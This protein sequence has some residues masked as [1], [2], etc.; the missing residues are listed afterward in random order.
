V[1]AAATRDDAG[2]ALAAALGGVVEKKLRLILEE[3]EEAAAAALAAGID[4]AA[5]AGAA[6]CPIV[7]IVMA[8]FAAE[9]EESNAEAEEGD[10]VN[11]VLV[12]PVGADEGTPVPLLARAVELE[13]PEK[14]EGVGVAPDRLDAEVGGREKPDAK[15]ALRDGAG[16]KVVELKV[17]LKVELTGD[18]VTVT[19][20]V[21]AEPQ[22]AGAV[23]EA[24][25][26]LEELA[27]EPTL[28]LG[29]PVPVPV[30]FTAEFALFEIPEGEVE[31]EPVSVQLLPDVE[32]VE[33]TDPDPE[34]PPEAP[35]WS[36][37]ATASACVSQVIDCYRKTAIR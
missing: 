6:D 36:I 22:P 19:V 24:T 18:A 1:L 9:R 11:V 17:E 13:T 28:E 20:T 31:L 14:E 34:S 32:L 29:N 21:P 16:L 27:P 37:R 26:V 2:L 12:R 5:G 30:A 35:V 15:V 10:S 7:L 3:P 25:D 8:G 33:A 4:E 23:F